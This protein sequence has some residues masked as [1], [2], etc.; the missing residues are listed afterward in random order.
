MERYITKLSVPKQKK[1]RIHENVDSNAPV[2]VE[3]TSTQELQQ[4]LKQC[5]EIPI[6]I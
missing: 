4:S 5:S 1:A 3:N 6:F 2:N